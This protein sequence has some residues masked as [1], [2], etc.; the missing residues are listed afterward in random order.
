LLV[1]VQVYFIG[2]NVFEE[3]NEMLH[4]AP[5]SIHRPRGDYVEFPARGRLQH[6]MQ[7]RALVAALRAA[8]TVVYIFADDLPS[9][10]LGRG[11]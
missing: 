7:L 9:G 4:A 6:R 1:Q 10:T 11:T 3:R 2:V 8:N 5:E